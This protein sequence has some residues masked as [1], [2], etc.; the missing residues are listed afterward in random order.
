M[1][2]DEFLLFTL[3]STTRDHPVYFVCVPDRMR[4]NYVY[5]YI[6]PS[7]VLTHGKIDPLIQFLESDPTVEIIA[8]RPGI[9]APL[10]I[11]DIKLATSDWEA[12]GREI[13]S[14]G[15]DASPQEKQEAERKFQELLKPQQ[16]Q[17]YGQKLDFQISKHWKV[18]RNAMAVG[19]SIASLTV[20]HSN[21]EILT[22][23]RF[24]TGKLAFIDKETPSEIRRASKNNRLRL[25]IVIYGEDDE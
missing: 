15:E 24:D 10:S 4:F 3:V 20:Q 25:S 7:L 11:R 2:A 13:M 21:G 5:G 17:I 1:L 23:V 18:I 8:I 16:K 22:Q 6:C 19:S 12:V 14:I 9:L